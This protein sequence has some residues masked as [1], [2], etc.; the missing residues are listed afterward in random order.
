MCFVYILYSNSLDRFYVGATC[1]DLS[2]RFRKHNAKHKGF[3]GK[4]NDWKLMFFEQFESKQE[5]WAREKF[6]KN[7]KSRNFLLF[8]INN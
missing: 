2:N 7:K 3:T 5:A 1:D 8:L 6:I 4:A